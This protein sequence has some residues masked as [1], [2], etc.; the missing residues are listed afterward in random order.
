[1]LLSEILELLLGL[2]VLK[3]LIIAAMSVNVTIFISLA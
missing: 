2:G 1:M 3:A